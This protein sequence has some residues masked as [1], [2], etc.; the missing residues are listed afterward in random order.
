MTKRTRKTPDASEGAAPN[1]QPG[2]LAVWGAWAARITLVLLALLGFFLSCV[3]QG[4][5]T[6]R[7]ALLLPAL[8][9]VGESGPL[10]VNGEPV[11]HTRLTVPSRGGTVYLDVYA[12]TTPTPPIPGARAG[13]I[14]I[15]GVGDNRTDPQLVNLSQSLARTGLVVM[16]M[17]TPALLDYN[18]SPL[19]EDAVVQAFEALTHWPG[20]SADRI[21]IVGFSAASGLATPAAADPRIRD[22]VAYV[23]LFGGFFDTTT[24][25]RDF[26][27]RAIVVDGQLRPWEPNLVPIQVL[28][29]TFAATLPAYEGQLL[30]EAASAEP[31]TL[32]PYQQAQLSP[33]ALA[34]YHLLA[35]DQPDRTDANLAALSPDMKALLAAL[36][37]QSVIA[38]VRTPIYLLHDRNDEYVPFTQSREFD[39][40]LIRLDHPHDYA[41]FGIFQHVEVRAGLGVGPLLRDGWSLFR[42]LVELLMPAS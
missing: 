33:P 26:G 36:A 34:A 5:A 35:G 13:V 15:P 10:L 2:R 8:L 23:T 6:A 14:M 19:D 7:A 31:V 32:A 22:R 30:Q 3:P 38:Q 20:V 40:A 28:A 25:L 1:T 39:A 11:R 42:V 41:E 16:N 9:T 12:P 37:P 24:L 4:R 18:L 29:N 17:T 21:G 27:R